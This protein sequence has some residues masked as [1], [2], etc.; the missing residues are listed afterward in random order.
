M[1]ANLLAVANSQG[2]RD[3]D[4]FLLD[5]SDTTFAGLT[6]NATAFD[7]IKN[8]ITLKQTGMMPNSDQYQIN[9][10]SDAILSQLGSNN[11]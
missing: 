1:Q 7:L 4:Q 3:F 5:G 2:A 10:R 11:D 9:Y 8:A 6:S